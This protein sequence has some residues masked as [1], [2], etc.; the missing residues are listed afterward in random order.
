M[1]Q[2]S[3]SEQPSTVAQKPTI[4]QPVTVTVK[5]HHIEQPTTVTKRSTLGQFTTATQNT[6][7]QGPT[8]EHF[9][10]TTM[11]SHLDTTR[12]ISSTPVTTFKQWLTYARFTSIDSKVN[13]NKFY[14]RSN[15]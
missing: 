2:Q 7:T 1:T 15:E 6:I 5:Y 4:E 12:T 14:G 13:A 3:P 10:N 11:T 8:I 9:A